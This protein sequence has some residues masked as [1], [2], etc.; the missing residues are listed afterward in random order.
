MKVS[1]II[2]HPHPGSFNHAIAETVI[3]ALEENWRTVCFH[4]LYQER[5]DPVFPMTKFFG[6]LSCPRSSRTLSHRPTDLFFPYVL[7]EL[8]RRTAVQSL[9]SL[10][11]EPGPALQ[12]VIWRKSGD[13]E[14]QN[15]AGNNRCG[16]ID[17]FSPHINEIWVTI[18][19][20]A[21]YKRSCRFKLVCG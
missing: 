13:R 15:M 2:A 10:G 7:L 8:G 6:M 18:L 19:R 20:K 9:P 12:S 17:T 3:R 11:I 4:D 21:D 1:V 14:G 5:F 16:M